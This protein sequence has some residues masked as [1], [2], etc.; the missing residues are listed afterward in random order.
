MTFSLKLSGGDV[1]EIRTES[2]L[3]I[4]PKLAMSVDDFY[5]QQVRLLTIVAGQCY[6]L[7][8]YLSPRWQ[9]LAAKGYFIAA[10]GMPSTCCSSISCWLHHHT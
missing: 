10:Q 5:A 8:I 6:C 1:F 7:S 2:V 3:Y 4:T 9:A